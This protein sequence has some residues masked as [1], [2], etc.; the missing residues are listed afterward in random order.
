MDKRIE[1]I[2]FDKELTPGAINAINVCLGLKPDEKFVLI[3]DE[4][5]S[6][7]AAALINEVKNTG[8][9]YRVFVLEDCANRPLKKMPDIILHNLAKANVSLY[10][11][12]TMPGELQSRLQMTKV[13]KDNNIRHGHMVDITKDIMRQGMRVDYH[14]IDLFSEALVKKARNAKCI[15]VT[16]KEGTDL[17]AVF[18]PDIKWVKTSGII[19]ADKWGNLP[20]GE[21]FTTPY[22]I[23]GKFV[24]DGVVGDY[25]CKKYGNLSDFPLEIEIKNKR[26][27]K[28][29]SPNTVL[30]DEF[31][32]YII[33]DEN[34]GKVGEFAIGTNT[35][36]TGL[37]GNILQDEKFPGVHIAFGHPYPEYTGAD[38]TSST[39]ID[40]VCRDSNIWFDDEKIMEN[41]VFLFSI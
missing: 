35:A 18:S 28:L 10:A 13:I 4:D 2:I 23:N 32:K 15:K 5:T 33:T 24:V 14:K 9:E 34:S 7:I 17:T 27:S 19:S 11:A 37:I 3:T 6:E 12:S 20:G 36:L 41:G 40:C 39:H 38:W 30:L 22:E 8:A 31:F 16:T 29:D 1:D 21:I 25:L 26:I